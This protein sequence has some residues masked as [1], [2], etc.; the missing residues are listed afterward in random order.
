[1]GQI[2]YRLIGPVDLDHFEP[3]KARVLQVGYAESLLASDAREYPGGVVGRVDQC[4]AIDALNFD[5]D[6]LA[7]FALLSSSS[8]PQ[9]GGSRFASR[10]A[11]QRAVLAGSIP[12]SR[13]LPVDGC[14]IT[15]VFNKV[16]TFVMIPEK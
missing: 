5:F 7:H 10:R 11:K 9:P 16:N 4:V 14:I 13:V 12:D 15:N 6:D 1:M 3:K 2:S 8:L